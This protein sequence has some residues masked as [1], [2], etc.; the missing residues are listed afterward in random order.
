MALA[1]RQIDPNPSPEFNTPVTSARNP[2]KLGSLVKKNST[3]EDIS[4]GKGIACITNVTQNIQNLGQ[5]KNMSFYRPP[6]FR[7]TFENILN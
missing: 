1:A 2:L 4:A 7:E 3:E 5:D 6:Q